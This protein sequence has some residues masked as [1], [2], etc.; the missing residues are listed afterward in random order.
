MKNTR[1]KSAL[2]GRTLNPI[3]PSQNSHRRL[4]GMLSPTVSALNAHFRIT[5]NEDGYPVSQNAKSS[6]KI[7]RA[8]GTLPVWVNSGRIVDFARIRTKSAVKD[9]VRPTTAKTNNTSH[10]AY[11]QGPLSQGTAQMQTTS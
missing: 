9:P 1:L 11:K 10:A 7:N 3:N 8:S 2:N 6:N 5:T 4:G